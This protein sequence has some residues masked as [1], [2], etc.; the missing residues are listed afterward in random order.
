M[1][2]GAQKGDEKNEGNGTEISRIVRW[3][4]K[5]VSKEEQ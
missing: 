1:R 4:R 3:Q 2:E 5:V